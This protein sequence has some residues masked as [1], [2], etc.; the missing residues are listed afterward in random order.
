MEQ[1]AVTIENA[2]K[3][4]NIDDTFTDDD[5]YI[6]SLIDVAEVAVCNHLCV[7]SIDEV[8]GE[9]VPPPIIHAILLMVANLY[10]NREPI[11]YTSVTEI[12]LSYKYLLNP[13][14]SYL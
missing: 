4:L 9:K 11:S 8:G 1:R 5:K 13:Y 12:P 2:K 14:I 3:H 7:K 6:S 10:A